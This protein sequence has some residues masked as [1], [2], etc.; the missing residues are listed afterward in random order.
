MKA[1]LAISS[2][3]ALAL[4]SGPAAASTTINTINNG[5]FTASGGNQLT[6]FNTYTGWIS[7][8]ELRSF[9]AFDISAVAETAAE[10]SITFY[11]DNYHFGYLG[12][13]TD[14]PVTEHVSLFDY[15]G[16]VSNLIDRTG[17]LA[18]FDDL[19]TGN[20]LG[21]ATLSGPGPGPG[22][23]VTLKGLMPQF[24]VKL[25]SAFVSQFNA[26]IASQDKTI[27]L[28]AS[29]DRHVGVDNG[30]WVAS[31]QEYKSYRPAAFLTITPSSAVPEPAAWAMMLF[32]F[33]L[34]GFGMRRRPQGR[35]QA[36]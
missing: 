17:G 29:L 11:G 3:I 22:R 1:L 5:W 27:A 33:G 4:T 24:T 30:M 28:G 2:A 20:L 7:D 8:T 35:V 15:S 13:Y 23:L 34:V 36:V 9:Y 18:A 14:V 10:I 32:G 31:G 26:A 6:N 16:P 19:G 25:S 12:V 21:E